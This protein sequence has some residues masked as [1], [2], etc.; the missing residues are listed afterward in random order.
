MAAPKAKNKRPKHSQRKKQTT[1]EKNRLKII[2]YIG[3]P[4]KEFPDRSFISLSVCGY[5]DVSSLYKL[6][7]VDELAE[8]EK[9]GLDLRRKK[10]SP[11]LARADMGLLK[12][13][14][15]GDPQAAKLCYQKFEN[16]K[17]SSKIDVGV[18]LKDVLNAFPED[19]REEIK[20]VMAEELGK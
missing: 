5:K 10:Y 15:L 8:I 19:I 20:K 12:R 16:W 17:E 4:N 1:K 6:F 18:T 13:A 3:D 11:E 9:E 7:T 14:S 2:E